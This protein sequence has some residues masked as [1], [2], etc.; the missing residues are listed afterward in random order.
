MPPLDLWQWEAREVDLAALGLRPAGVPPWAL[1]MQGLRVGAAGESA[2]DPDSRSPFRCLPSPLV[3]WEVGGCARVPWLGLEVV[4][5]GCSVGQNQC[6]A[7]LVFL[8]VPSECKH[9]C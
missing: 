5:T 8:P 1:R 3:L 7:L 4:R 2:G 6:G 9:V